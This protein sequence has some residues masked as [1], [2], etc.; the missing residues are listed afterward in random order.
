[1]RCAIPSAR[2]RTPTARSR[3]SAPKRARC[4]PRPAAHR[5]TTVFLAAHRFR[6]ARPRSS[7]CSWRGR[8]PARRTRCASCCR[9]TIPPTSGA[10]CTTSATS[11]APRPRSSPSS[12]RRSPRLE[13]L[14][15]E[16][17]ERGARAFAR[18]SRRAAPTATK[19]SPS[20]A[21]G[22]ACWTPSALDI[23][24]NRREIQAAAADEAR[25]ARLVQE[26]G[27][28]CTAAS[29]DPG[30]RGEAEPFVRAARQAA[31]A[32]ARGTDRALRR[33]KGCGG[34][35][36]EGRLHP[37]AGGAAGAGRRRGARWSMPTG[38]AAS[39]TC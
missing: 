10:G 14:A 11:R 16:A 31:P 1:M 4:A 37:R 22:G 32:G 26:I 20:A 39:A 17:A 13:R 3:A 12:A 33:S 21:S 30:G 19:C 15:H 8:R 23:R 9:A 36:S 2:S 6:I 5:R 7:A 34:D 24:K 35:R 25:L 28:V 18:S 27:R 38:C 29:A